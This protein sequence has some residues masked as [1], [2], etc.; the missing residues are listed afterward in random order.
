MSGTF[1]LSVDDVIHT[2]I[3]YNYNSLRYLLEDL[4]KS[5]GVKTGMYTFFEDSDRTLREVPT[6]LDDWL[7]FGPHG[8]NDLTPPWQQNR[9]SQIKT[10]DKIYKEIN[11]FSPNRASSIRLHMYSECYEN[12]P[13]FIKNGVKELFTTHRKCGLYRF[14]KEQVEEIQNKGTLYRKG[15]NFTSTNFRIEDLAEEGVTKLDFLREARQFLN[16]QN[17]IIIYSHEYEHDRS[18]V[19]QMFVNCVKWMI[20]D[21]KLTPEVP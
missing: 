20:E 8:L 4:W 17:R 19:N 12:S 16:K 11:R 6:I 21:L 18:E 14:E 3:D 5:W 1:H 15:I 2:L 7:Y 13:Y 10:F 9:V